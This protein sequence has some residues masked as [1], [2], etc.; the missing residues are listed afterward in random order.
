M[1]SVTVQSALVPGSTGASS[2][3]AISTSS[4]STRAQAPVL[5]APILQAPVLQAPVL[6]AP[7][8][9]IL[10][11]SFIIHMTLMVLSVIYAVLSRIRICRYFRAFGANFLGLNLYLCYSNRVLHLWGHDDRVMI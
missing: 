2:T 9:Q 5:S 6:Q 10:W 3:S 8:K 1:G 7:N 4:T 11:L